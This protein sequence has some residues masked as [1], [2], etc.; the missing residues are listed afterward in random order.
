LG[1]AWGCVVLLLNCLAENLD[2]TLDLAFENN[3]S[4]AIYGHIKA[5]A[6]PLEIF[7]DLSF[8]KTTLS[9]T[10]KP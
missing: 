10:S 5:K 1:F 9:K 8:R 7:S 6:L 3:L 2:L 4:C